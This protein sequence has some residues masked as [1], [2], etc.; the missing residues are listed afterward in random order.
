MSTISGKIGK[1]A[2]ERFTVKTKTATIGI[3]GTNFTVLVL[4][5]GSQNIYCTYGAIS[6][7]LEG[8]SYIVEQGFYL[9]ISSS[10]EIA[11]KPFEAADLAKMKTTNFGED[12]VL[13]GKGTEDGM[14][15]QD[16]STL[17][18]TTETMENI[19]IKDISEDMQD[20]IQTISS[21]SFISMKGWSIDNYLGT[22]M[23]AKVS[24]RFTEDGSS[25]DTTNSWIQVLDKSNASGNVEYDNWKFTLAATPTSFTNSDSFSTTFTSVTL[26]PL[27]SST[28]TNPVLVSS[29]FNAIT[30]LANDDYMSWGTWSATVDFESVQSGSL[31]ADSSGLFEGG[32]W[33]SGV[34]TDPAVV[35]S[36]TSFVLYTGKYL[37]VEINGVT[38]EEGIANLEVD[39]AADQATLTIV[40][41]S[42]VGADYQYIGMNVIGNTLSDGAVA[43]GTSG[44]ANGT[45]YGPNAESAGGNFEIHDPNSATDV[46][47][48]Y[49]VTQVGP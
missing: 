19:S 49:Q 16:G 7:T 23:S 26:T 40:A 3:R 44:S 45:F 41:G 18:T 22:N 15:S 35:A 20:A 1:I 42:L 14:D 5:D 27:A 25:F 37:A 32:L 36:L 2:P 39:F 9:S 43:M 12:Q 10:G 31:M 28:S 33:I 29:S 11:I 6:V 48:V 34:E 13:K 24:L 30:D 46:K 38:P 4:E 17:D 21:T 47:G 8:N